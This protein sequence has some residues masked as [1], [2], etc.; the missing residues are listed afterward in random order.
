[1]FSPYFFKNIFIIIGE[2]ICQVTPT[3]LQE[4]QFLIFY[5]VYDQ[6]SNIWKIGQNLST[7]KRL[8]HSLTKMASTAT[9]MPY[10]LANIS[11]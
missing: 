2:S 1:M 3:K 7:T 6:K 5:E 10:F 8:K 9:E 4:K 11:Q